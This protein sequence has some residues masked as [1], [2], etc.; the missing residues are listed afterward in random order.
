LDA[1]E[2]LGDESGESLLDAGALLGDGFGDEE[3]DILREWL[4]HVLDEDVVD[5]AEQAGEHGDEQALGEVD[6][7]R[8][9]GDDKAAGEGDAT[10]AEAASIGEVVAVVDKVASALAPGPSTS[11]STSS[12]GPPPPVSPPE[13]SGPTHEVAE[14]SEDGLV[15]ISTFGYVRC[16][17]APHTSANTV[18]LLCHYKDGR[19]VCASCHL[20]PRCAIKVGTAV[21]KMR[22]SEW[23]A[24]GKPVDKKAPRAER[25]AEGARH[26]DLW[27]HG[28]RA[29]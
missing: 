13:G 21:S 6:V 22:L 12:S 23:L 7:E 2:A 5:Q 27:W 9:G 14:T 25:V 16:D 15:T 4:D 10:I 20:H 17:R 18:G 24:S 3:P 19:T 11:S 26:R 28:N 1:V 29:M 8:A